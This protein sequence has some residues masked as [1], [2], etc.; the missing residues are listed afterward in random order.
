M[1]EGKRGSFKGGPEG[2]DEVRAGKAMKKLMQRGSFKGG[3][4][5]GSEMRQAR[6]GKTIKKQMHQQELL[7]LG[8]PFFAIRVHAR[9]TCASVCVCVCVCMYACVAVM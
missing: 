1:E 5:M 2:G 4:E 3:S 6:A 7:P 8:Q 9:L